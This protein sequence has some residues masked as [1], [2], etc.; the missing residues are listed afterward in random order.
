MAQMGLKY[1]IL[2]PGEAKRVRKR[3]ERNW[4]NV[5]NQNI[6][7]SMAYQIQLPSGRKMALFFYDG[8]ISRA[9]GFEKLLSDGS[10]FVSWRRRSEGERMGPGIP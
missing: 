1:A 10:R 8:P 7:P 5:Q 4:R 9:V 6:D 3:S 2:A